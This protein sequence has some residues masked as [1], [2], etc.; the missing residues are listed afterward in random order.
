MAICGCQRSS[1]SRPVED[2]GRGACGTGACQAPPPD[3]Q[4]VGEGMGGYN[5]N[6][7]YSFVGPGLGEFDVQEQVST[8]GWKFRRGCILVMGA[9]VVAGAL[10]IIVVILAT[11]LSSSA[12]IATTSPASAVRAAAPEPEGPSPIYNCDSEANMTPMKANYCCV[13]FQKFCEVQSGD[14]DGQS[15]ASMSD[16]AFDCDAGYQ[17]WRQAWSFMK[18]SWCCRHR[19]RGCAEGQSGGSSIELVPAIPQPAMPFTVDCSE[20]YQNW[21]KGWS[22]AKKAYCCDHEQKGCPERRL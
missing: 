17:A 19:N 22:S 9:L 18:K 6:T 4:Y 5:L 13:K 10:G 8:H 14:N 2:S 15:A 11:P 21:Q 1:T 16:G 3:W 12:P 7:N 20:G